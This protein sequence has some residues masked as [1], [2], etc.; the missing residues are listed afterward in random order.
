MGISVRVTGGV[1]QENIEENASALTSLIQSANEMSKAHSE[2]TH[3]DERGL[4]RERTAR[5]LT[6]RLDR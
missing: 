3:H 1:I 6:Y 4:L 5:T 2:W